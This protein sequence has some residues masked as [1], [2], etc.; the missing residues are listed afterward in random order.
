MILVFFVFMI[1]VTTT[2][3]GTGL[4]FYCN[5]EYAN[6]AAFLV[7]ETSDSQRI[8][9]QFYNMLG[10]PGRKIEATVG[11]VRLANT[12]Q[13]NLGSDSFVPL[14]VEGMS[15]TGFFV[16]SFSDDI[17]SR[18]LWFSFTHM[19]IILFTGI[20]N[21]ILIDKDGEFYA[22]GRLKVLLQAG[23]DGSPNSKKIIP[24]KTDSAKKGTWANQQQL[25]SKR[26]R[27]NVADVSQTGRIN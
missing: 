5:R 26:R 18:C 4:V 27:R 6:H 1:H 11:N 22:D 24:N 10:F 19:Y 9:F 13:Y 12:V 23:G 14:R 17:C 3:S 7:Y 16:H 25:E 20:K 2:L 21:N 15:T 8:G